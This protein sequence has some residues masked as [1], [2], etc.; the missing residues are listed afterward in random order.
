MPAGKI[1][2]IGGGRWARTI[3]VVLDELLPN[4]TAISMHSPS[5]ADGLRNWIQNTGINRVEVANQ[6]PKYSDH[7]RTDAVIV[8]NAARFHFSA[9]VL[10]LL[11]GIPTLV[12]KPF[13]LTASDANLLVNMMKQLNVPLCA[14]HV[15]SF[16][17]YMQTFSDNITSCGSVKKINFTWSDPATEIR[18][19]E[20]KRYDPSISAIHDIFPH[21]LSFLRAIT[22]DIISYEG[23]MFERGGAKIKLDLLAGNVLCAVNLERNAPSR[24]RLIQVETSDGLQVLDFTTEPGCIRA[25][26]H[27]KVGD[28]QWS[29]APGPL[30]SM[31]ES[32]LA[33]AATGKCNDTRLSPLLGLE[34]CRFTDLAVADYRTGLVTWLCSRRKQK[35]DEDLRYALTELIQCSHYCLSDG[36]A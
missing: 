34:A 31:L 19:G 10:A 12:E 3:V 28:P 16:A 11:A 6:W 29:R 7:D 25:G 32:F 26:D 33:I 30:R 1:A 35:L 17:R 14:G 18:H 5:N 36:T 2:V 9:T 22:T 15:L 27:E 4:K 13:T 8:A 23:V 21:I 24:C 20:H